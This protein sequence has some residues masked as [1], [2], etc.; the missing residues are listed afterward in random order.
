MIRVALTVA[1]IGIALS[2]AHAPAPPAGPRDPRQAWIDQATETMRADFELAQRA[3]GLRSPEEPDI[4]NGL[5]AARICA[6]ERYRFQ[7]SL[8]Q[9]A[10]TLPLAP[11]VTP[12]VE[13]SAGRTSVEGLGERCEKLREELESIRFEAIGYVTRTILYS[14]RTNASGNPRSAPAEAG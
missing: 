14:S 6:S 7:M 10:A 2:C 12:M 8:A 5:Q 11:G 1:L 3:A 4:R 9:A 13:T